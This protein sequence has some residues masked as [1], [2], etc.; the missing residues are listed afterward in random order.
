MSKQIISP[1]CS[2]KHLET[3]INHANRPF[4]PHCSLT[5]ISNHNVS[6]FPCTD[7]TVHGF[8][9]QANPEHPLC[10]IRRQ[11][12]SL[13]ISLLLHAVVS[14]R[15]LTQGAKPGRIASSVSWYLQLRRQRGIIGTQR[16]VMQHSVV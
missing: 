10:S 6:M 3:L 8:C 11:A 5:T 16:K 15:D 13:V 12:A 2:L 4:R 9:I 7:K 1:H 14:A